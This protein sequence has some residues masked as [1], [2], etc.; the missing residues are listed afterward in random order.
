MPAGR[1]TRFKMCSGEDGFNSYA[2]TKV[3]TLFFTLNSMGIDSRTIKK[4]KSVKSWA[5]YWGRHNA[6][7][8][9]TLGQNRARPESTD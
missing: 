1:K 8:G 2:K 9:K 6:G 7:Q 3:T 5:L 4:S